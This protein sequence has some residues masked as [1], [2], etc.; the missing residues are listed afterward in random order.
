MTSGSCPRHPKATKGTARMTSLTQEQ[1][2]NISQM[3]SPKEMDAD[4]RKRQYSALRR[5]IRSS[6]NPA[7]LNKFEMSTD[8]ER[9][10]RFTKERFMR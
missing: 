2:D 1:K 4:E 9:C 5:A 7:L 3:S 8:G 6:A 10:E